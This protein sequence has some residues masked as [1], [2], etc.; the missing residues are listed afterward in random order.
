MSDIRKWKSLIE[1]A[2]DEGRRP[3]E[4]FDMF[5]NL[6]E[7]KHAKIKKTADE[8]SIDYG[9]KEVHDLEDDKAALKSLDN[10][11]K[12]FNLDIVGDFLDYSKENTGDVTTAKKQKTDKAKSPVRENIFALHPDKEKAEKLKAKA[13]EKDPKL[14]WETYRYQPEELKKREHLWAKDPEFAYYYAKYVIEGRFPAGEKAMASH[15]FFAYY[16]AEEFIGDR[17]PEGEK[18]IARH[19][20][21][22]RDYAKDFN[23]RF[24]PKTKTFSEKTN[25]DIFALHPDKEKAEKLKAKATET[26]PKLAWEKY[27]D[28][29]NELKKREHLWAKDPETA[30]DYA[31]GVIKGRWPKGEKAIASDAESAYYYAKYV[32]K[33]RWTKG[34]K[35]LASD[36]QFAYYYAGEFI[37]DRWPAG[38]KAIASEPQFAYY[39]AREFIGDRWPEGEGAIVTSDKHAK[40][41]AEEFNLHFDPKTRTFSEKKK[42]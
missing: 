32:I 31:R 3:L 24:D 29:I 12:Q 30:Y 2:F 37:G 26:N 1:D 27:E 20:G 21:Y 34:E 33:G 41:Y 18:A 25:E 35:A 5:P 42:K 10:L 11:R 38:E 39:Y 6:N 36:P 9:K 13:T 16:Y 19:S 17:W 15:P 7:N 14:A 28:D 22:A 23:L 8:A 4:E 40:A